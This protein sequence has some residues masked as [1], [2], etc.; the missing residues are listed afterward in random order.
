MKVILQDLDENG[1]VDMEEADDCKESLQN[2]LDYVEKNYIGHKSRVG[3]S[4]PRYPPSLW[5][6]VENALSGGQMSTNRNEGYHSRLRASIKQNST[7]WALLSE[8]IDVEAETRAKREEDRANIDYRHED[9]ASEGE[10]GDAMPVGEHPGSGK[11]YQRKQKMRWLRNI[12]LKR[13][14]YAPVAY[15]KRV[16]HLEAF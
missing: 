2:F 4:L 13:E 1:G 15:L 16:S 11:K 8:L 10:D 9:E 7:I 3:W 6:Q 12:I 5:N 14:E